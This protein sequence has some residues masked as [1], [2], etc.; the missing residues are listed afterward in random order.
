MF[1]SLSKTSTLF[2]AIAFVSSPFCCTHAQTVQSRGP[3]EKWINEDVRW[4]ITDQE[5]F[6]FQ[7]LNDDREKAQFVEEF[8]ERRN[9]APGARENAFK[10]D[11][12]RRLAYA[13]Q[14]FAEGVPGW[15]SDRGRFY[16]MYGPPD[17]VTR[18]VYSSSPGGPGNNSFASEEWHWNYIKGLGCDV[19]LEFEDKCGCGKYELSNRPNT[20]RPRSKL[21]PNCLI[22]QISFP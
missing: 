20:I 22:D 11:H 13:N 5:R 8:W 2:L 17:R 10:T 4:I 21:G 18:R 14:H 12:Y 6:E 3:Y 15:K 7:K 1:A 19:I 16:I 9:P